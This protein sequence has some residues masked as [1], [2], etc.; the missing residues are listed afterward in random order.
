MASSGEGMS[1]QP[2]APPPASLD[3]TSGQKTPRRGPDPPQ[4]KREFSYESV[5][6]EEATSVGELNTD[7]DDA[8]SDDDSDE[9]SEA[10]RPPHAGVKT[11]SQG[12]PL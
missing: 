11:G 9:D 12:L 6:P 2:P 5:M 4:S 1:G 7:N 8:Q 3:A 10:V